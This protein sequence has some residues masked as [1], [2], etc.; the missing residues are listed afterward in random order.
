MGKFI[1]GALFGMAMSYAYVWYDVRLPDWVELPDLVKRNL[2]TAVVDD[3]LY[4][5]EASSSQRRRALEV[6][7][8]NQGPRAAK[9][10]AQLGHPFLEAI[11]KK[12]VH[13]EARI[14]R[15]LWSAYDKAL[16]K[17]NIR[18]RLEEKY[19]TTDSQT[20]KRRMLLAAVREKTFLNAWITRDRGTPSETDVYGTVVELSRLPDFKPLPLGE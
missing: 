3:R 6:Y 7:F 10:D 16:A 1:L 17:P 8:T 12:R 19:G 11:R 14:T 2:A 13:R 15:G 20:L 9:L 4:D 5:L 18:A